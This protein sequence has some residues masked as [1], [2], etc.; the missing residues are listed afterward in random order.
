MHSS[1]KS[2]KINKLTEECQQYSMKLDKKISET[3]KFIEIQNKK[4]SK[5]ADSKWRNLKK[6]YIEKDHLTFDILLI[7]KTSEGEKINIKSDIFKNIL[8][9]KILDKYRNY[10]KSILPY[11]NSDKTIKIIDIKINSNLYSPFI[12]KVDYTCEF[13]KGYMEEYPTAKILEIQNML[14]APWGI[15][16]TEYITYCDPKKNNCKKYN[17]LGI[18]EFDLINNIKNMWNRSSLIDMIDDKYLLKVNTVRNYLLN[19]NLLPLS[20]DKDWG[21]Y[22]ESDES[23]LMGL[24]A[25]LIDLLW[26]ENLW[27]QDNIL[28]K[29]G[30]VMPSYKI[31]IEELETILKYIMNNEYVPHPRFLIKW[32]NRHN[33]SRKART[34]SKNKLMRYLK[35]SKKSKSVPNL[36][37]NQTVGII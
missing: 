27:N 22:I 17:L 34:A 6:E 13:I 37:F 11:T 25:K 12:L 3:K 19:D 2:S 26:E 4:I 5:Y 15:G 30:E 16:V 35:N 14:K 9:V 29:F 23:K 24:M 36:S 7:L 21:L 31:K 33:H 1:L 20:S 10:Y 18:T 8:L 28:S 32:N